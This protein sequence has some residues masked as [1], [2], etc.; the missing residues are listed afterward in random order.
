MA[1]LANANDKK[2]ACEDNK[3]K[4]NSKKRMIKSHLLPLHTRRLQDTA[5]GWGGG[6]LV[7]S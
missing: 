3:A 5:I 2:E 6:G 1:Y 7:S 4:D